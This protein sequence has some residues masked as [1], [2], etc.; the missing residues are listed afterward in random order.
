[1]MWVRAA[2]R[3]LRASQLCSKQAGY[4][5]HIKVSLRDCQWMPHLL[6]EFPIVSHFQKIVHQNT[7]VAADVYTVE[8]LDELVDPP[9]L[10]A[11]VS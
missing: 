7:I 9:R 3:M 5:F 8:P 2:R 1:M 6:G 10:F 4:A 11:L